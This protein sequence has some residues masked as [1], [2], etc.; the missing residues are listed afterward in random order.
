MKTGRALLGVAAGFAAGAILGIL[1]APDKGVN[2]RKNL[3]RKAEDLSDAVNE[4][5]EKKF[6]KVA[7]AVMGRFNKSTKQSNTASEMT[8]A[9]KN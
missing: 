2:T 5:I 8:Q 1:F 3:S 4:N 7:D 9:F 6:E